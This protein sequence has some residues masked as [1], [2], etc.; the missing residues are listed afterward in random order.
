MRD[1]KHEDSFI[2]MVV[3]N[4]IQ[5]DA[6]VIRAA[7]AIKNIGENVCVISC[8]SDESY[9]NKNFKSISFN[10]KLK[11]ALLLFFSVML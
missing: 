3:Y 4:A 8:N 9:L 6:R 5:Y 10:S 7:E 1:N 11:G 2:L